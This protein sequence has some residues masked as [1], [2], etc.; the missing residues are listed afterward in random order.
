MLWERERAGERTGDVAFIAV[1][2]GDERDVEM[3][4]KA[5]WG[6]KNIC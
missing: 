4:V 3:R 5:Q 2:Q 6:E 1:L